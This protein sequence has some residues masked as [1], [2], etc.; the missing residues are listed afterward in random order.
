[1]RI[2][3]EAWAEVTDDTDL[4]A[5]AATKPFDRSPGDLDVPLDVAQRLV[6]EAA[7]VGFDGDEGNNVAVSG[8]PD[9]PKWFALVGVGPS[10]PATAYRKV[11]ARTVA[12]AGQLRVKSAAI[13]GVNS[14]AR[15]R[16]AGEGAYLAGY[17]FDRYRSKKPEDEKVPSLATVG[18][19][20]RSDE[21]PGVDEARHVAEAICVGRDLANEHPGRCTPVWLASQAR[22]IAERNGLECEILGEDELTARGFNLLLAVGRGSAQDS[23]LLHLTYRADGPIRRKIAIVGKGV[24]YDS[25]GYSIKVMPHQLNMHLDMGGAAAVLGAAEAVGRTRPEGVEV[26]FIVPAAE[27]L[28]SGDAYKVNEII[29]GYGGISVE[30]LNTDAEGRLI[31]ADALS[32]ACELEPDIIVDLAT[33]TGACVVALGT[34]TAGLF[35]NEDA[36]AASILSAAD[37]VDELMWRLPLTPRAEEYLKSDFADVR[38]IGSVRW[39]GAITAAL[40]LKRF[41]GDHAWAHIDLAGPA[42]TESD[43]E[44]INKGGTGFGVAVL[45]ALVTREGSA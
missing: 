33:L 17:A 25:G 31:L 4:V 1:M 34:E 40:F 19:V 41:V 13:T 27:N 3:I 29:T 2:E 5:V 21:G 42:M 6:A 35:S 44:Y 20:C 18:I 7:R 24:T 38:N 11:G 26:H 32:Y 43:W 8:D 12:L 16:F 39:G 14:R 30:V 22:D 28:V 45:H 15:A 36:L 23:Q 9:G 10:P 37:E